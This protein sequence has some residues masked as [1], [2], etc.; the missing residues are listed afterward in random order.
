MSNLE[1]LPD[2]TLQLASEVLGEWR[3]APTDSYDSLTDQQQAKYT[4]LGN[5]CIQDVIESPHAA[6]LLKKLGP[7]EEAYFMTLAYFDRAMLRIH[8][9]TPEG[10]DIVDPRIMESGVVDIAR[11]GTPHTHYGNISSAVPIGRLIHYCFTEK[12]GQDYT[13]GQ[14]TYREVTDSTGTYL[15][16]VVTPHHDASLEFNGTLEC[17][18]E[19][20]YRMDKSAI[21]VISWP[22]PTVTVFL[23]DTSNPKTTAAYQALNT[24]EIVGAPRL[25]LD[26]SE[27]DRIWEAFKTTVNNKL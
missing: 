10:A 21:H 20:G 13:V 8:F 19:H 4:A 17:D 15:Q 9:Y 6:Q 27:Q 23:S 12:E 3:T 5:A 7:S 16:S 11:F 1:I 2:N 24:P 25:P 26:P 22:E 18:N 14:I